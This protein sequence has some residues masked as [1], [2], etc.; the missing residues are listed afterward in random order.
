MHSMRLIEL[1]NNEFDGYPPSDANDPAG[2]P[3]CGAMKLAE[4]LMGQDLLGFHTRS[5]LSTR[6]A[7][8]RGDGAYPQLVSARR[9]AQSQSQ[10]PKRAV[11]SGGER[12]CLAA[13]GHLRQRQHGPIPGEYFRP[14]RYLRS[15]DGP[16]AERTG[17]P[18]LYYRADPSGTAH[19]VV[20]PDNPENIYSY[21]DNRGTPLVGCSRKARRDA[22]SR[23]PEAVLSEYADRQDPL[24]AQPYRADTFILISAGP[25]GL[26]GTADD[27]CNFEWEYRKR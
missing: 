19:D 26:Y 15:E 13:R 11:S 5:V 20:N 23:G 1:F 25:D 16:V 18:I 14:V 7:G 2:R 6:W 4:A 3:Y 24:E 8:C 27:I 17:M 21:K 22:P 10:S 9:P 12:Q